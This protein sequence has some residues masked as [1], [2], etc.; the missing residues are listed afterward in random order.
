VVF[1]KLEW[2]MFFAGIR[3]E[4]Q[5]MRL[6]ADR[7]GARWY[8]G[9]DLGEPWPDHSSLTRMRERYGV[10]VFRRFFAAIVE[11][12]VAAGLVWGKELYIDAT[13]MVANASVE[14]VTP[15]FALAAR[16]HGDDVFASDAGAAGPQP[17]LVVAEEP[18]QIGPSVEAAPDLAAAKAGRHDWLAQEGQQDRTRH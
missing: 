7:L 1:C 10:A 8:R 15:R 6:V 4:R 2:V 13:K 17:P 9:Y 18:A 3:S 11:R 16:A 5:L 12:C 14:S